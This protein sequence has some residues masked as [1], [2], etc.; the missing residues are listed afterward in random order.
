MCL[1]VHV[2]CRFPGDTEVDQLYIV[3]QCLGPLTSSQMELFL[4]NPR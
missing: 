4:K 1:R 2:W 3:Q